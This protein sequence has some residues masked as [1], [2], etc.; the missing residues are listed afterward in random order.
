VYQSSL[1][2]LF[3]QKFASRTYVRYGVSYGM[4]KRAEDLVGAQRPIV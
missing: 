1:E 4:V 2:R 3:G